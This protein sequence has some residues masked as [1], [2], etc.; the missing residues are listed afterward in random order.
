MS[1]QAAAERR[2]AAGESSAGQRGRGLAETGTHSEI[3]RRGHYSVHS[4]VS[5]SPTV[6]FNGSP[7]SFTNG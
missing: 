7:A 6:V 3:K 1:L 4:R 2:E 5:V